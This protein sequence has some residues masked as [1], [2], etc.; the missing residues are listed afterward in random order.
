MADRLIYELLFSLT[1]SPEI[2]QTQREAFGRLEKNPLIIQT[3]LELDRKTHSG[4]FFVTF[5]IN[6]VE[7]AK[8]TEGFPL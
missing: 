7:R 4:M 1:A 3:L 8:E 6:H 2:C 5:K